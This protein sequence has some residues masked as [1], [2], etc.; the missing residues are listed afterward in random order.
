VSLLAG[1]P[2]AQR[3][4]RILRV[5]LGLLLVLCS[6]PFLIDGGLSRYAMQGMTPHPD[7]KMLVA[8]LVLAFA[9]VI[10]LR[11][12]PWR[13]RRSVGLWAPGPR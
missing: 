9:G 11:R 6:V 7:R 1:I 8:G 13:P 5:L 4:L 10:L 3:F 2:L 12:L